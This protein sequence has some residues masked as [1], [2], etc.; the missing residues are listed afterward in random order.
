[1]TT[2]TTRASKGLPLTWN[3]VDSNF[4]NLN[5][6]KQESS[7]L[8]AGTGS[9]LVG[10]LQTGVGA[11]STTV[12]NKLTETISIK[13]FGASTSAAA[14]VNDLAISQ[15][16]A[17]S[18][19]VW[20]PDGIYTATT[21]STTLLKD[22]DGP[23]YIQ[24][25]SD[26]FPCGDIETNLTISF[27][28]VFST[29]EDIFTYL[30][31]RSIRHNAT[32]TISIAAGT[33]TFTGNGID[34]YHPDGNRIQI[35]GAGS[36]STTLKFTGLGS[37]SSKAG[38]RLIGTYFLGLLDGVTLDGDDWNGHAHGNPTL[39][40]GDPNDP[41]GIQAKNG[42][43]IIL[44]SD[45]KIYRFARNG[46]FAY[47]GSTI[48][49]DFCIVTECGSDAFVAS[50]G[51]NVRAISAQAI[52]GWGV[53]FFADLG[54]VIWATSAIA[55]GTKFRGTLGGDGFSASLG[56]VIYA[57][58]SQSIKNAD[59]GYTTLG[60]TFIAENVVAGGSALNANVG[61]GIRCQN[62]GKFIGDGCTSSYNGGAGLYLT[63][64]GRFFG[65]S[66][67]VSFNGATG[68]TVTDC[69]NL[70]SDGFICKSNTGRGLNIDKGSLASITNCDIQSNTSDGI[71]NSGSRVRASGAIAVKNNGGFGVQT[72][73]A[74]VVDMS[75]VSEASVITGNVGGTCS[76][77]KDTSTGISQSFN[78]VST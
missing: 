39:G 27:P 50:T 46:V 18:N 11:V 15:A 45:V 14:S 74:G 31:T 12:T 24:I 78:Y 9:D 71:N 35:I 1:M 2:I 33:H 65:T 64:D 61:Q 34:P 53:G 19:Q 4:T 29:M 40:I 51:S 63:G 77:A 36:G 47:Q 67:T 10:F 56:G 20:V 75:G 3:E 60:G 73:Q 23:G 55:S 28:S 16:L 54:G 5:T 70:V 69:S 41:V 38:I 8:A 49:A 44:G 26:V 62:G 17:V 13:D 52:D 21:A 59:T 25:L 66:L 58:N 42:A 76:P 32:V 6:N 30:S 48:K 22:L 37:A 57:D 68:A 72:R 43:S 7:S